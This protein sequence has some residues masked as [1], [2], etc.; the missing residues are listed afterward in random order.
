MDFGW[1]G[2]ADVVARFYSCDRTL[3]VPREKL[4]TVC[5]AAKNLCGPVRMGVLRLTV[6]HLCTVEVEFLSLY[7][8]NKF[9]IGIQ[10]PIPAVYV[11]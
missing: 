1:I 8:L 4:F 11:W 6:F 5:L 10:H 9:V 3:R 2:D 7:L